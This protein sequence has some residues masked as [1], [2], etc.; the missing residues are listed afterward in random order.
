MATRMRSCVVT[1]I[2]QGRSGE[3]AIVKV[4]AAM[5]TGAGA[6][7][8]DQQQGGPSSLVQDARSWDYSPTQTGYGPAAQAQRRLASR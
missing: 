4:E 1:K 8:S 5:T 6:R 7:H 3:W 2:V